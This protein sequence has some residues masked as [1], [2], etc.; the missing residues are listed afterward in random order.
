M[1][2][3]KFQYTSLDKNGRKQAGV[4]HA[5]SLDRARKDLKSRGLWVIEIKHDIATLATKPLTIDNQVTLFSALARLT[6]SK[7]SLDQSLELVAKQ[8]KEHISSVLLS[9]SKNVK[10]GK[11]IEESFDPYKHLFDAHVIPMLKTAQQSGKLSDSFDALVQYCQMKS[12]IRSKFVSL[13]MYPSLLFVMA[14]LISTVFLVGIVP[15]FESMMHSGSSGVLSR[16]VVGLSHMIRSSTFMIVLSLLIGLGYY[17]FKF[18]QNEVKRMIHRLPFM[19]YYG[20]LI[21]TLNFFSSMQLLLSSNTTLLDALKQ[22]SQSVS[23]IDMKQ[24]CQQSIERLSA[25]DTWQAVVQDAHW[26][27]EEAR[28]SLSSNLRSEDM[29]VTC[30]I[31][32]VNK[33]KELEKWIDRMCS[34]LPTCM[35]LLLGLVIGLMMYAMLTPLMSY[36]NFIQ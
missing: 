8:F 26:L 29:S 3:Q 10:A 27:D 19:K 17:A 2:D 21:S 5:G 16:G 25:G 20:V 1:A 15:Q 14:I 18:Y 22:S 30:G 6:R 32:S 7:I 12:N 4:I 24:G 34:L 23:D 35:I 33:Y 31:L 28:V 11:S 9:I 36:E 13:M